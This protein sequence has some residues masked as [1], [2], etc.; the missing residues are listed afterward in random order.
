LHETQHYHEDHRSSHH[1][2]DR[3]EPLRIDVRAQR[4]LKA[5]KMHSVDLMG[6]G[7]PTGLLLRSDWNGSLHGDMGPDKVMS[8]AVL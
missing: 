7:E 3:R 8:R 6:V 1:S 5:V 4:K 2:R